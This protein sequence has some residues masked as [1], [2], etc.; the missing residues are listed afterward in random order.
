MGW[1]C[2]G[3]QGMECNPLGRHQGPKEERSRCWIPPG[4]KWFELG[5]QGTGV[6]RVGRRPDWVQKERRLS[7]REITQGCI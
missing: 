5:P 2:P 4:W 1:K 7:E 6:P 3:G